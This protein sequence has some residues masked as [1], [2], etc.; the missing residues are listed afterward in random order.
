MGPSGGRAAKAWPSPDTTTQLGGATPPAI[1]G[2]LVAA[3]G[4]HRNPDSARPAFAH[5]DRIRDAGAVAPV[6]VAFW[7]EDPHFREALRTLDADEVNVVPLFVS[8][9]YCTGQVIPRA[10]RLDS[11]DPAAW[12]SDALDATADRN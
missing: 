2:L 11:G 7:T 9:R 3:H 12:D 6:R 8:E 5:V 4:S 10:L 1:A